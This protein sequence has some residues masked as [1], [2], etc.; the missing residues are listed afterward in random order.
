MAWQKV[1]VTVGCV[2]LCLA[3]AGQHLGPVLGGLPHPG[4]LGEDLDDLGPDLVPVLE[5]RDQALAGPD[6]GSD[7]HAGTVAAAEFPGRGHRHRAA[8]GRES[9]PDR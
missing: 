5:G 8:T 3:V 4:A 9:V 2:G 6:V 7:A 1:D